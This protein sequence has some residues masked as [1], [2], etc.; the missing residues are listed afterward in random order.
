MY[1]KL[2]LIHFQLV[3]HHHQQRHITLGQTFWKVK[4]I[5]CLQGFTH[6]NLLIFYLIIFHFYIYMSYH[7]K[8][9]KGKKAAG[10]NFYE[11]NLCCNSRILIAFSKKKKS[12]A[13]YIH[14]HCSCQYLSLIWS[15]LTVVS[16]SCQQCYT[17]LNLVVGWIFLF[18]L[19][20]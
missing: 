16:A 5:S 13:F 9:V 12:F 10:L 19:R 4:V 7:T 1:Q 18:L 15:L 11:V 8:F 6:H 17:Y 20:N 3:R 2:K 14:V